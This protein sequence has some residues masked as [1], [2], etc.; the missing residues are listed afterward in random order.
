M[1]TAT[2]WTDVQLMVDDIGIVE[3]KHAALWA[4]VST[5]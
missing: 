3:Y 4:E 2:L 5:T 1:R